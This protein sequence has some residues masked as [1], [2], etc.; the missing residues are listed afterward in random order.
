MGLGISRT[1][2]LLTLERDLHA[3]GPGMPRERLGTQTHI[4]GDEVGS[5][6]DL[7]WFPLIIICIVFF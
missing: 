4:Y 1:L 6:G 3:P 7:N 2:A 5:S